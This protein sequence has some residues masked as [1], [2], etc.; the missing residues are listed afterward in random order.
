MAE[1]PAFVSLAEAEAY[2]RWAGGRIMSEPEHALC[3]AHNER[4]A[5]SD[6]NEGGGA[7]LQLESAGWEWTCTPF[8][9]FKGDARG[10]G[11]LIV[12]ARRCSTCLGRPGRLAMQEDGDLE[13]ISAMKNSSQLNAI[14]PP[15]L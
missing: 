4:C 10:R 13:K 9:P 3:L 1:R 7:L 2:C 11:G 15:P 5:L 6:P 12:R 8:A 14:L